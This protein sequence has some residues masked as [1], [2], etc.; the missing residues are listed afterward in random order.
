MSGILV[1]PE[2]PQT[3]ATAI[4]GLLSEP[5]RVQTMGHA[6]RLRAERLFDLDCQVGKLEELYELALGGRS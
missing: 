1:P 6:A 4:L 3:L 2:E 5:G